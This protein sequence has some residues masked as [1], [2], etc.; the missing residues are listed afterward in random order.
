MF[1]FL[2]RRTRFIIRK[3]NMFN[4]RSWMV[5]LAIIGT[6]CTLNSPGRRAELPTTHI[7]PLASASTPGV[8]APRPPYSTAGALLIG[9]DN[10]SIRFVGASLKNRQPGSFGRFAGQMVLAS[11][12]PR[13]AWLSIEI[14]MDSVTTEIP[15]LTTHLK[16]TDFFDVEHFPKAIFISSRVEAST[17][18]GATHMITGDLTVRGV[19]R[20][21]TIPARFAV[22]AD[23]VA[24]DATITVRQ[25][26]FGME[27]A[28]RKTDDVVPVTVST[29]L[30]RH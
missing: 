11:N 20:I 18:E 29:R 13:D 19:T 28:A 22:S 4:L 16:R 15:L 1:A 10:T 3:G 30:A 2:A 25:S 7:A 17:A 14:D 12:D 23:Q 6:G 26:E 27:R 5:L 21:L 24:L 9:P 8:Q